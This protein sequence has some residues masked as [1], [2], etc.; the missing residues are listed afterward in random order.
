M[1][2][3]FPM[4]KRIRKLEKQLENAFFM[5]TNVGRFSDN[6]WFSETVID[7][8]NRWHNRSE[9]IEKTISR[10]RKRGR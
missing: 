8:I 7:Y 1:M 10:I 4:D 2:P 9:Q 6:V 5:Y 3:P